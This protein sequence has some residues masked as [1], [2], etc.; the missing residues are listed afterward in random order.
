[1]SSHHIIRDEQEPAL[2]IA[3]GEAC[4]AD[5][6]GELLEWSPFV[7]VLDGAIQRVLD[8]GI[9]VDVLLGDF[10]RVENLT[11]VHE[12]QSD[13]Q[14]INTPDQNK[15]DLEKAIEYLIE[16]GHGA[17]N[18]IWATGR[19]ADHSITNM[20]N[21]VRYKN[22]IKAVMIDSYSKIFPI[23]GSFEKWYE[24]GTPISL[25]P[26]GT[27][28]GITTSG[29]LYNLNNEELVLGFRSGNSNEAAAD[30]FVKITYSK[31]DLLM[32]ECWD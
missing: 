12:Q 21:L 31:G 22:L 25:I 16:K 6:L 2:I 5:I 13:I 9:K 26:I 11:F 15:T 23:K 8:L 24:K 14:I 10:D 27:A 32:M 20:T 3:N 17:V 18:I 4:D 29:L 7:V 1:M 30:G 19:R 28:S